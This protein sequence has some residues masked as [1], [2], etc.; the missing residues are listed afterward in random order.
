M[1][2]DLSK[3]AD[4]VELDALPPWIRQEI[5]LRKEEILQKLQTEGNFVFH[6]PHGE[7]ATIRR[8]MKAAAA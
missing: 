3:L 7:Q 1:V 6:G 5:E 2:S 4:L 8:K